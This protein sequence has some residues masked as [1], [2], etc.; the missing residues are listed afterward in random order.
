MTPSEIV[1]ALQAGRTVRIDVPGL[2]QS[3]IVVYPPHPRVGVEFAGPEINWSA[4]G[5]VNAT[6]AR[7]FVDMLNL[8]IDAVELFEVPA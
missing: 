8:A 2:R 3:P 6:V 4:V 7:A 5:S 1:N